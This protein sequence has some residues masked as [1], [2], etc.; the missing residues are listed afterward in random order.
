MKTMSSAG[1]Y[2]SVVLTNS[3]M[4]MLK[5]EWNIT[6]LCVEHSFFNI[7]IV[8]YI[9]WWNFKSDAY[10]NLLIKISQIVSW[11]FPQKLSTFMQSTFMHFMQ[12]Y[13][14]IIYSLLVL[15]MVFIINPSWLPAW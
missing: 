14:G 12:Y 1:T 8:Y 3:Q 4:V 6:D 5:C 13:K 15:A 7:F 11:K 10:K 9:S 2:L